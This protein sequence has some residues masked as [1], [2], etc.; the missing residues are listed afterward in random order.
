MYLVVSKKWKG[1]EIFQTRKTHDRK[2]L[3]QAFIKCSSNFHLLFG[4]P[5]FF[6][7]FS[8][9]KKIRGL[10]IG[11]QSWKISFT[12]QLFILSFPPLWCI[13]PLN[14]SSL[15]KWKD[16]SG[17]NIIQRMEEKN[18]K[19]TT[20]NQNRLNFLPSLCRYQEKSEEFQEHWDFWYTLM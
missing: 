5:T 10:H 17:K 1:W 9:V 12:G 3:E 18:Q 4:S 16:N 13:F 14:H 6:F 8:G 20:K 2:N 7:F 15:V 19:P 11:K